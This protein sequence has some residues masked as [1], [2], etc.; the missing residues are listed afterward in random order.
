MSKVIKATKREKQYDAFQFTNESREE[1]F[2]F[3]YPGI[4]IEL[5][6]KSGYGKYVGTIDDGERK[7]YV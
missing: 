3:C 5:T 7:Q 6:K 4:K 1:I 2:S